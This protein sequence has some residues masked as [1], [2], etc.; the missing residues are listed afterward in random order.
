MSARGKPGCGRGG[1]GAA[2]NSG[3]WFQTGNI[4]HLVLEMKHGCW[5]GSRVQMSK[6]RHAANSSGWAVTT[7]GRERKARGLGG[8]WHW[9]GG[10]PA[11]GEEWLGPELRLKASRGTS[12]SLASRT[13]LKR[14]VAA[15]TAVDSTQCHPLF[16]RGWWRPRGGCKEDVHRPGILLFPPACTALPAFW[17]S[18]TK[19]TFVHFSLTST[20]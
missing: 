17:D 8:E 15:G 10:N 19:Q 2:G 4:G 11:R 9:S 18:L 12:V 5:G 16:A 7:T 20:Q 14:S 13:G 1:R 6:Y 3:A